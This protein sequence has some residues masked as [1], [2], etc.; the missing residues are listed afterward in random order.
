[1]QRIVCRYRREAALGALGQQ[2]L[3]RCFV[4]ALDAAGVSVSESRRGMLFS[5][6]LPPGASSEAERLVLE[7][8]APCDPHELRARVNVHLPAGLHVEG[9][10]L[11]SPGTL[12][13]TPG[14]LD[15]A[16]YDVGWAGAPSADELLRQVRAFLLASDITFTRVREKKTQVLNARALVQAIQFLAG[17][18]G[19]ARLLIT[20]SVGP[21]GTLRPEEVLSVLGCA[22]ASGVAHVHRVALQ[23]SRWRHPAAP[24]HIG[25]AR[26][27]RA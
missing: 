11:A 21:Q 18:D 17:R 10:W 25:A 6:P 4:E 19:L 14:E 9:V 16:V 20:V 27:H 12:D 26:W 3:R 13:E 24:T 8:A 15:E 2:E 7:L 5:A 22:P 1:M 23:S